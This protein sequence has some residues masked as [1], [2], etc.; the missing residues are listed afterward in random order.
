MIS[1]R[2]ALIVCQKMKIG[3]S[4]IDFCTSV[5]S[6]AFPVSN[7][8]VRMQ[9]YVGG[10]YLEPI[11]KDENGNITIVTS[12]SHVNVGITPAMSKIVRKL[13]STNIPQFGKNILKAL[14]AR[15]ENQGNT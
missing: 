2:D 8:I 10:Y 3:D 11:P 1:A 15:Q 5:E 7:D 6:E 9:L 13:A 14:K 12:I 4:I